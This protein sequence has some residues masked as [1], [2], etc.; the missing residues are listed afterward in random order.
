MTEP[1]NHQ[2]AITPEPV[3][4]KEQLLAANHFRDRRDILQALLDE[5]ETY[6]IKAVEANINHY[7]KGKVK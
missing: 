1:E 7:M 4:S 5:N 6:T 2:E 3:F